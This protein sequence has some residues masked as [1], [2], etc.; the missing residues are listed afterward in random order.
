MKPT[1]RNEPTAFAARLYDLLRHIPAGRVVTYK[2]LAEA[3]GC[4]SAQAVG[5]A[6][7][8]NPFA[9]EVPCHR[10]IRTDLK[11]GGYQGATEGK[12][13]RRK[14]ELLRAEGVTFHNGVLADPSC[15]A[16]LK[17]HPA[18]C[19]MKR[20]ATAAIA[21]ILL[22]LAPAQGE[23]WAD[24]LAV[25]GK[26]PLTVEFVPGWAVES[27]TGNTYGISIEQLEV[28][29]GY[30]GDLV[31]GGPTGGAAVRE[32]LTVR[33][34]YS[35]LQPDEMT[36]ADKVPPAIIPSVSP[37]RTV[38]EEE[39]TLAAL[40]QRVPVV[41]P[42]AAQ[43]QWSH[44]WSNAKGPALAGRC[45]I[46]DAGGLVLYRSVLPL[47]TLTE[48]D[49]LLVGTDENDEAMKS[50]SSRNGTIDRVGD[51]PDSPHAYR[52]VK[53]VWFTEA[54][55]RKMEGREALARRLLLSGIRF[56]GETGLVQRI[57]TTLGTGAEG[58]AVAAGVT[59]GDWNSG[60]NFSLRS[61]H[62]PEPKPG[63][64]NTAPDKSVFENE[65]D[66]FRHDRGYYLCWTIAGL[67]VYSI[68]VMLALAVV[69]GRLKGEQ[70]TV[71][72]WLLPAWT[73]L[74]S[75]AIFGGGSLLLDRRSRTDVTEYRLLMRDW[76]EMHCRVV[77]SAMTFTPGRPEWVL[78]PE[79]V[80]YQ[81][82]QGALDGWWARLDSRHT[83][84]GNRVRFER[85]MTGV[86]LKL[87]AGWF[88]PA[89]AP[90]AM[91]T[92]DGIRQVKA[93]EDVDGV[94]VLEAGVWRDLGPMK[95][96]DRRDPLTVEQHYKQSLPGLP[97]AL[98]DV[99]SHWQSSEPCRNPA[100]HHP[101]Q[102]PLP[103]YD[104]V[105]VA[106]KRDMQPRVMPVWDNAVTKGRVIWVMQCP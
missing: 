13:L 4:R 62:F 49:R 95:A 1:S 100:H 89:Q 17:E 33:L 20:G 22:S 85:Q 16:D 32:P 68:G 41:L 104:R 88:E 30:E 92:M 40:P 39:W 58:Y 70:R 45:E 71:I 28:N 97:S 61:L 43:F 35:V 77:A 99:Y 82:R 86:T 8:R 3:A 94:Y 69:F 105:V 37:R 7:K 64:V 93:L 46:R 98:H 6:L 55:W 48:T 10:V 79:A 12:S 90:V 38:A 63:S 56:S 25:E 80:V 2:T 21:A 11:P 76:P 65:G 75:A 91:E 36:W 14:L 73:I 18:A 9:P 26:T 103:P 23:P 29:R 44:R 34:L 59:H 67:L 27:R 60:G 15:L 106:W 51:L 87:E 24:W 5:Q 66:L 84:S 96:G 54:L 50:L 74:C 42:A 53:G 19:R 78:P 57:R 52:Q 102:E 47:R 81:T 72:W 101:P 83:A 31:I